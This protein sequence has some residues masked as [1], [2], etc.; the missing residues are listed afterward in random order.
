M[1]LDQAGQ[2]GGAPVGALWG[3]S[4]LDLV[5]TGG[6]WVLAALSRAPGALTTFRLDAGGDLVFAGAAAIPSSG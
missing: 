6:Q 2:V 5:F 3:I 4:D 1:I